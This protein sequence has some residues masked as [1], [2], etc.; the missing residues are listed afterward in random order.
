M[1]NNAQLI[2]QCEAR[3]KEWLA[4]AF[5][6]ETRKEVQAMLDN[7]DKT[8]LIDAFYRDLEFGTGGLRG[9]MGA[10]TNRMNKYIRHSPVSSAR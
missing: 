10:G 2:A 3:A 5:D 7:P 1:E 9:I 4:P 6:E 8:D